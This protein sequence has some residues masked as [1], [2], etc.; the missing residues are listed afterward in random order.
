MYSTVK[1]NYFEYLFTIIIK[2]SSILTKIYQLHRL[3]FLNIL[4]LY[5][6]YSDIFYN[7]L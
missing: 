7:L 6:Y 5:I 2:T 3:T 4:L 1:I